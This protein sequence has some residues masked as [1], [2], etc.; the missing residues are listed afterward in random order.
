MALDIVGDG[1]AG[2]VQGTGG[3]ALDAVGLAQGRGDLG[4]CVAFVVHGVAPWKMGPAGGR[5]DPARGR[6][7]F[8]FIAVRQWA[9]LLL[10]N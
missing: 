5:G 6:P 1:V 10:R 7:T 9:W 2:A 8:S 3:G 4:G